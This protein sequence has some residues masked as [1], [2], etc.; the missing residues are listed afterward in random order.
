MDF[1]KFSEDAAIGEESIIRMLW[2]N[3][4]SKLFV[5]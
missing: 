4:V 2:F 1:D 3:C 5:S